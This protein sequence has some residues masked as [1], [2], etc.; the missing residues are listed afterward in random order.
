MEK[1]KEIMMQSNY[2][3]I[4]EYELKGKDVLY[5]FETFTQE[6]GM[7]NK[8]LIQ[9]ANVALNIDEDLS[10]VKDYFNDLKVLKI[11]RAIQ[12]CKGKRVFEMIK[13]TYG[14]KLGNE[15]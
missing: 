5:L 10:N 14:K 13:K 3:R 8:K 7:D 9:Y 15:F 6:R 12:M 1:N 11:A 2:K 4:I